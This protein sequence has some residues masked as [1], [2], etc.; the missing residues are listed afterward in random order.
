MPIDLFVIGN[1]HNYERRQVAMFYRHS[2]VFMEKNTIL[3]LYRDYV[4]LLA[5]HYLRNIIR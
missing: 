5:M 2:S 4:I 1:Q 3:I